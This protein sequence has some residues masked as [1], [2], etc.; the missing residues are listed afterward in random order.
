MLGLPMLGLAAAARTPSEIAALI[1]GC[2]GRTAATLMSIPSAPLMHGT[3]LLA[4]LRSSPISPVATS[5]RCRAAA[6]TPTS[7]S[8]PSS[9]TA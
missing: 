2:V 7:C 6:S 9:A 4:G 3:G 1:A 8:P 5:S